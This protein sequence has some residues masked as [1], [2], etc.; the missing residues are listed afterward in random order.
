MTTPALHAI[1][2]N[3]PRASITALAKPWVAD[4]L[5]TNP[6][7]DHLFIYEKKYFGLKGKLELARQLSRQGFDLAILLQNAF[8]AAFIA[9]LANIPMR[10]GYNTDLRGPFLTHKVRRKKEIKSK[11]QVFYYL[12]MLEGLGLSA[13]SDPRLHLSPAKTDIDW[14]GKELTAAGAYSDI[15]IGLNP[16]A[17]YG[18]AKKWLPEY[19]AELA[20]LLAER[21]SAK[22]IVF[23]TDADFKIGMEL[24][25]AAPGR[26]VNT[27]GHTTLGQAVGLIAQCNAFVTNDSGLMHVAAALDIPLVAIFG[28]T[29]AVTTGPFSG[30][31]R[32]I[33]KEIGCS[34]CLKAKC[35]SDFRCMK[36]ITPAEVFDTTVRLLEE[37]RT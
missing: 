32:I 7:I 16:G 18:P 9:F 24:S 30:K 17:A 3:F 5:R 19:F 35:P 4:V 27:A 14:A 37:F 2:K 28:S 36:E 6:D 1:R 31:A 29:N 26:V 25:K 10:A 11:H 13:E 20:S 21:T 34:P 12:N 8:E 15:L 22:M 33:K 23:G